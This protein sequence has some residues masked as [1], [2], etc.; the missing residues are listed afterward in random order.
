MNIQPKRVSE[1][2]GETDGKR[3]LIDRLWPRGLTKEKARVEIWLKDLL[4]QQNFA[5]GLDTIQVNGMIKKITKM[6]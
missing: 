6:S 4:L 5:H 1:K 2:P 3:I